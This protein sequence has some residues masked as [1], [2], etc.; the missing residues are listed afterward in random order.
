V[1]KTHANGVLKIEWPDHRHPASQDP[2]LVAGWIMEVPLV[3]DPAHAASLTQYVM[4]KRTG[5]KTAVAVYGDDGARGRARKQEEQD[6]IHFPETVHE[7]G[8]NAQQ[9]AYFQTEEFQSMVSGARNFQKSFPVE[10]L[11]VNA[12]TSP[13]QQ[14]AVMPP[15]H[16]SSLRS[17][18]MRADSTPA[19]SAN[20]GTRAETF[21]T[22]RTPALGLS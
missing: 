19:S 18:P 12:E 1:D 3:K 17:E 5:Q 20:T 8:F 10:P 9:Q 15:L 7:A 2:N 6:R 14:Q 13:G 4:D 16:L 21:R 11:S 22:Q